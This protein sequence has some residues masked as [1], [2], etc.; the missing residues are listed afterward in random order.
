[1]L[2]PLA[3]AILATLPVPEAAAESPA[4]RRDRLIEEAFG[5]LEY[6]IVVLDVPYVSD[7][8]GEAPESLLLE[9]PVAGTVQT[10]DLR[11]QAVRVPGFEVLVDR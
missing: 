5:P 10:I 4:A 1:M 3:L 2:H 8:P 7:V 6:E 9:L 11:R